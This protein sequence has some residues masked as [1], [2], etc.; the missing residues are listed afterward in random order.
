MALFKIL[1]GEQENRLR[2][3]DDQN[4]QELKEGYCYF[5]TDTK[6]FYVDLKTATPNEEWLDEN[7]NLLTGDA[8]K[9]AKIQENKNY[10]VELNAREADFLKNSPVQI[11]RWE[12]SD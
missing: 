11:I 3:V 10:R 6:K 7:E 8:L 2:E 12:A 9:N 5:S 4:Y 1:K